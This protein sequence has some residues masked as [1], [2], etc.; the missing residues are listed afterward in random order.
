MSEKKNTTGINW[1]AEL[2]DIS[3]LEPESRREF[4]SLMGNRKNR[5]GRFPL[6]VIC[7][8][9]ASGKTRLARVII[10][11][12]FGVEA[13]ASTP[14]KTKTARLRQIGLQIR[15]DGYVLWDDLN[16]LDPFDFPPYFLTGESLMTKTAK[17]PQTVSKLKDGLIILTSS[18]QIDLPPD[19][20]RRAIY[21]ELGEPKSRDPHLIPVRSLP[22]QPLMV[23]GTQGAWPV[24]EYHV[25]TTYGTPMS[26]AA[27]NALGAAG[28]EMCATVI[29]P[30]VARS[31]TSKWPDVTAYTFKRLRANF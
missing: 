31:L 7:G 4:E 30:E 3:F 28:W 23:A 8:P 21:I 13:K 15:N 20:Q 5:F 27:M 9:P 10:R 6:V 1:D 18:E 11:K 19:L 25:E 16:G 22:V 26:L 29:T 2:K 24:W 17:R 12:L 14:A